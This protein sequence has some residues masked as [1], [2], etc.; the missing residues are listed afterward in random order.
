MWYCAHAIHFFEYED[1]NQSDYHVWEH[2]YLIEAATPS[3][4][5]LAGISRARQDETAEGHSINERPARL[6]FAG[7]RKVVECLDLDSTLDR[8][9]H[10]TE[11]SY[12][13]FVVSELGEFNHLLK[14]APARVVYED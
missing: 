5:H 4:A 8:P 14:G 7:I 12:S 3:D 6:K 9:T 10:G 11:L 1:G 13:G 2:L